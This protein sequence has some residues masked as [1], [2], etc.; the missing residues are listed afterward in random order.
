MKREALA[1]IESATSR[2]ED[3]CDALRVPYDDAQWNDWHWQMRHRLTRLADLRMAERF[4]RAGIPLIVSIRFSSGGLRGAPISATDGHLIKRIATGGVLNAPWGMV[5]PPAKFGV[6]SGQLLVGNFGDGALN[7]FN[8]T[9]G[10]LEGPLLQTNGAPFVQKGLWGLLF[11]NDTNNQPS[12]TLFYS[13]GPTP[14]T[15]VFGRID[16]TP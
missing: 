15:G 16:A 2:R 12:N 5:I 11:G 7:M 6:A 1:S 3:I 14:T 8:P 4:I 9:T 10:A 13:A